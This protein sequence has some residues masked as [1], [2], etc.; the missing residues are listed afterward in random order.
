MLKAFEDWEKDAETTWDSIQVGPHSAHQQRCFW[1][2]H[3]VPVHESDVTPSNWLKKPTAWCYADLQ[4]PNTPENIALVAKHGGEL[5]QQ[6]YS[7]DL[8]WP[9][10]WRTEQEYDAEEYDAHMRRVFGYIQ[11]YKNLRPVPVAV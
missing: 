10:F 3:G 5:D 1:E 9:R 4:L 7:D 6:P 2:M 11:E 8:Y